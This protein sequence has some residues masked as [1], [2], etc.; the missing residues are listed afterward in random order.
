MKV[1]YDLHIHSCLSP[2]GEE[3]MT[4]NNIVN[5]AM[6][7][8]LDVIA[9]ADHNASQNV[10]AA[11][12]VAQKRDIVVIPA[13]ELQTSEEVH[14]LCLF[15]SVETLTAFQV[16]VDQ[17]LLGI[18]NNEKKFGQQLILD[19]ED[20]CIGQIDHA[21]IFSTSLTFEQT[22]FQVRALGGFVLPAHINRQSNGVLAMLGFIPEGMNFTTVEISNDEAGSRFIET[23][24]NKEN[25]RII[26]NSDAHQ[27][28]S[29]S[30]REFYME[31]PDRK[32]DTVFSYLEG[33][34]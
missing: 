18:P 6:I 2:C 34:M 22:V 26:R 4:P 15:K 31:I 10:A 13:M 17:H 29:I 1:Y 7:K 20:T 23:Y 33:K 21:L 8:G 27:L 12:K 19:A 14:L 24:E 11:M 30:E 9:I 25:Y 32:I 28:M 5:M 16:I 3:E